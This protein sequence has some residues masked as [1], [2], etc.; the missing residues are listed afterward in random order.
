MEKQAAIKCLHNVKTIAMDQQIKKIEGFLMSLERNGI[1]K[2]GQLSMVMPAE[3]ELLGG[4]NL[5]KCQN[6]VAESCK[7]N[8]Q[9]T[10]VGVCDKSSNSADCKNQ[11][12]ETTKKDPTLTVNI[13]C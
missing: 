12:L 4:D 3:L 7:V 9:C 5:G 2:S 13:Q 8:S 10:N 6:S 11:Q 1:M